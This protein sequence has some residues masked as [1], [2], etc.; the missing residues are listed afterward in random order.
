MIKKILI[1][2]LAAIVFGSF[3]VTGIVRAEGS[4][5]AEYFKMA[6]SSKV[7]AWRFGPYATLG[8]ANQV[9]NYARSR[10][11]KAGIYYGGCFTC[12]T[13]EYFVDVWK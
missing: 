6:K 7:R 8:R 10:G 4:G 1:L 12:G 13:R 2:G 9:A 11:Y 5:A 3:P